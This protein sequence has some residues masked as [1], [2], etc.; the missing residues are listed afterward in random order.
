M[1]ARSFLS[2]SASALLADVSTANH[3]LPAPAVSRTSIPSA[4]PI[5]RHV[6]ISLCRVSGVVARKSRRVAA[7]SGESPVSA[8]GIVT[9]GRFF[10]SS[11]RATSSPLSSGR[12]P[13]TLKKMIASRIR[14]PSTGMPT[15]NARLGRRRAERRCRTGEVDAA[16]AAKNSV[17]GKAPEIPGD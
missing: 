15:T 16:G 3:S 12:L 8:H 4:V 5:R 9:P 2:H 1:A 14:K 7:S 11:R 13:V 6:M 17:S 10:S